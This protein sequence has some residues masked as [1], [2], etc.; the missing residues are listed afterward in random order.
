MRLNLW[1]LRIIFAPVLFLLLSV[2]DPN[3][4]LANVHCVGSN[5]EY[6]SSV[7]NI[8]IIFQSVI[9]ATLPGDT[10]KTLGGTY[11]QITASSST[12]T[13]INIKTSGTSAQPHLPKHQKRLNLYAQ[14]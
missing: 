7:T 2:A 9:N 3:C 14:R 13:F 8:K 6:N 10:I 11:R 1:K 4:S 12:P 5:Q